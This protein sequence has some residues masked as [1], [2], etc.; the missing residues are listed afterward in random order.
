L[1]LARRSVSRRIIPGERQSELKGRKKHRTPAGGDLPVTALRVR[2]EEEERAAKQK[3]W[4]DNWY[5]Q[6]DA[7]EE[8]FHRKRGRSKIE[9]KGEWPKAKE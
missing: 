1:R 8:E 4:A 7:E 5:R 3:E 9:H 6:K 2:R